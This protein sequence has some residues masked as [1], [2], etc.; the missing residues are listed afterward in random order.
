MD[1]EARGVINSSH[2]DLIS[3]QRKRKCSATPSIE[4]MEQSSDFIRRLK[5]YWFDWRVKPLC[6]SP[7]MCARNG[8]EVVERDVLRCSSCGNFLSA[9]L[10]PMHDIYSKQKA[11]E[12]FMSGVVDAHQENCCFRLH[13]VPE[14]ECSL[15]IDDKS[16]ILQEIKNRLSSL[17]RVSECISE[18]NI[19]STETMGI[20]A[21][22]DFLNQKFFPFLHEKLLLLGVIGWVTK[23]DVQSGLLAIECQYCFREL[24]IGKFL[25][26]SDD[27]F[28]HWG[29]SSTP[30]NS[31]L[32]KERKLS[33][34]SAVLNPETE[35]NRWCPCVT[36]VGFPMLVSSDKQSN[37]KPLN[38]WRFA[39]RTLVDGTKQRLGASDEQQPV[40]EQIIE[41]LLD[42]MV[43]ITAERNHF[44]T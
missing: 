38:R 1:K 8:W 21:E 40:R 25:V 4:D 34:E 5:T 12:R 43:D 30:R 22:I 27:R 23:P 15:I 39:L 2:G 20:K 13:P 31:N 32:V 11:V 9:H 3:S 10:P 42:E 35:H 33:E 16:Q 37:F 26:P 17:S 7:W 29:D 18:M 44:Y 36:Q 24:L 6:M 19:V 28:R 14:S 41:K